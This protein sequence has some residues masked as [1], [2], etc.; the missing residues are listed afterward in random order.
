MSLMIKEFDIDELRAEPWGRAVTPGPL[1]GKLLH[2]MKTVNFY[3]REHKG[4]VPN[5]RVYGRMELKQGKFGPF[6]ELDLNEESEEF[7]KSLE[8]TLRRLAGGCLNEKPWNLKFPIVEYGPFYSI[9][10]KVYSSCQLVNMKV[11][12]SFRSYCEMRPYHAF[13]GK[14]KRITLVANKIVQ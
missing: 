14:T 13:C 9:H 11:G 1:G 5:I 4:R 8:E 6:L 12:E 10:C 3:C 7:F 2:Q